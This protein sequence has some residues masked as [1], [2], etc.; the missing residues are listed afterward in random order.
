[1]KK[2]SV[3]ICEVWSAGISVEVEANSVAEA[4][5]IAREGYEN[6]DDEYTVE[7]PPEFNELII[8]I[9]ED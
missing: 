1:M 9:L 2:Y 5:E 7:Q 3:S 8:E 4:E 6:G